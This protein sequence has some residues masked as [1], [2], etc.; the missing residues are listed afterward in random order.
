MSAPVTRQSFPSFRDR[1][2]VKTVL[3]KYPGRGHAVEA[4]GRRA[5]HNHHHELATR[6]LE[7]LAMLRG[8]SRNDELT[9]ELW[10]AMNET[11]YPHDH[12]GDDVSRQLT[13][14]TDGAQT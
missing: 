8:A 1:A 5:C 14:F 13:L 6:F 9:Y 12:D 3:A 11:G 10:I 7:R 4:N 2:Y